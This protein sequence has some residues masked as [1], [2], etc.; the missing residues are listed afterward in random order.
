MK[1]KIFVVFMIIFT[2]FLAVNLFV[3]LICG[4]P[5]DGDGLGKYIICAA[6]VSVL[7]PASFTFFFLTTLDLSRKLEEKE[8]AAE[9]E[10]KQEKEEASCIPDDVPIPALVSALTEKRNLTPEEKEKLLSYLEEL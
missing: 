10:L 9:A 1:R 2:V 7:L 3:S 6:G 8:S 5:A 4:A